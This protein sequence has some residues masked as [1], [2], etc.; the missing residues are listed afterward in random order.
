LLWG[1]SKGLR[2]VVVSRRGLGQLGHSQS[3]WWQFNPS[4]VQSKYQRIWRRSGLAGGT[5]LDGISL[6]RARSRI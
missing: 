6:S 1:K 3:T 4:L 5:H 2:E